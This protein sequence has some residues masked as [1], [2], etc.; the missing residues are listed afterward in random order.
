MNTHLIVPLSNVYDKNGHPFIYWT[1]LLNARRIIFQNDSLRVHA[2]VF[3]YRIGTVALL[4]QP[5]Q[6]K[7]AYGHPLDPFRDI[8]DIEDPFRVWNFDSALEKLLVNEQ[9]ECL[10]LCHGKTK[11]WSGMWMNIR[12]HPADAAVAHLVIFSGA[13]TITFWRAKRHE[14]QSR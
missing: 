6:C 9:S 7:N 2:A 14:D 12:F 10:L 3:I 5:I 1:D 13:C 4:N 8:K 11:R